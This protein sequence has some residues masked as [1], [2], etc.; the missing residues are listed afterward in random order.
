M[1]AVFRFLG[2]LIMLA[3]FTWSS[4]NNALGQRDNSF[5]TIRAHAQKFH[6]LAKHL[7]GKVISSN[8]FQPRGESP[9]VSTNTR[10]YKQADGCVLMQDANQHGNGNE[11]DT[12][13]C[14]NS[15]YGFILKKRDGAWQVS[16]VDVRN[17]KSIQY[18][19]MTI[20]QA[21]QNSLTVSYPYELLS[22]EFKVVKTEIAKTNDL[23]ATMIQYETTYPPRPPA[24]D[25]VI[26]KGFMWLDNDGGHALLK[27]ESNSTFGKQNGKSL[28]VLEYDGKIQG[29][30]KLKK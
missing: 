12:V 7:Q 27:V 3:A 15:R 20:E 6:A 26:T 17:P 29:L 8:V 13:Y 25:H 10:H 14:I 9:M 5:E 24:K 2:A 4:L 16:A 28:V 23:S 11:D 21:V 30:P 18:G 19:G 1:L 22:K